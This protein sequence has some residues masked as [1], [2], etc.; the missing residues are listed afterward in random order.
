MADKKSEI[1][2]GSSVSKFDT[3]FV[4]RHRLSEQCMNVLRDYYS[5]AQHGI[6]ERTWVCQVQEVYA[7]NFKKTPDKSIQLRTHVRLMIPHCVTVAPQLCTV[8]EGRCCMQGARKQ[9]TVESFD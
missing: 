1:V 4:S 3:E 9:L 2:Q 6:T 7:E 5:I 8:Y